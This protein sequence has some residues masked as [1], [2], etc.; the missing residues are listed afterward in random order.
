MSKI[1]FLSLSFALMALL[2]V[3]ERTAL[4]QQYQSSPTDWVL[5]VTY[6]GGRPPA[7]QPVP[8]QGA[9]LNGSWYALFGHLDAWQP[10]AGFLPVHAVNILSR[11]E[12]DAVR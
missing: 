7:Y 5:E 2:L 11:Q 8:A 3:N 6:Y 12:G 10:P 1:R 9:K 4:S